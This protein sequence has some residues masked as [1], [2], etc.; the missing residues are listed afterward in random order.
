MAIHFR[1]LSHRRRRPATSSTP[2]SPASPTGTGAYSAEHWYRADLGLFQSA[3]GAAATAD[4]AS[5]G[6]WQDQ[7]TAADHIVQATGGKLPT[8]QNGAA[9]LLNGQPVI[10]FD[11]GDCLQGAFTNGGAL[12]QPFTILAVAKMDATIVNDGAMHQLYDGDDGTN[13]MA[14]YQ[15]S[16]TTPDQWALYAGAVLGSGDATDAN[17]HIL[18]AVFNNTSSGLWA[19]GTALAAGAGGTQNPDGLTLG[20]NNNQGSSYWKGDIAEVL[21]YDEDLAT[22]DKNQVAQYLATRYGLT[23]TAIT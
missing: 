12:A 4:G 17:W 10:R 3:G 23:W 14:I 8:L 11:G 7:A 18:L 19:D 22:A 20:A 6:Q 13:R 16:S 15:D 21:I 5:V 1:S 9:D 2:W